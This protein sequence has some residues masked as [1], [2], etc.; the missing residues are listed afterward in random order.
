MRLAR[1]LTAI[2]G[3]VALYIILKVV[4]MALKAIPATF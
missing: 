2:P 3:I 1:V 4:D